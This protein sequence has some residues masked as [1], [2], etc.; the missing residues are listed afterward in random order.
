MMFLSQH[1]NRGHVYG[2][3]LFAPCSHVCG[4]LNPSDNIYETKD[5]LHR[6]PPSFS[7]KR[8][9]IMMA[10]GTIAALLVWIGYVVIVPYLWPPE[11][12]RSEAEASA[13]VWTGIIYFGAMVI[14]MAAH[15]AFDA[16]AQ[17]KQGQ[18]PAF[19]PWS[20]LQPALV[21]PIIFLGVRAML[22]EKEYTLEATLLSFQNGFFWQTVFEKLKKPSA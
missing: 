10:P 21:S 20:F 16:V 8:L 22:V 4:C 18:Q 3:D 6:G 1:T 5:S 9:I 13:P 11:Y 2:V 19:D 12:L 17:R 7:A 14:G 15:T